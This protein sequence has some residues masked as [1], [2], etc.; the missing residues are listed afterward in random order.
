MYSACGK[1]HFQVEYEQILQAF[2]SSYP[3]LLTCRLDLGGNDRPTPIPVGVVGDEPYQAC[4][5]QYAE[6]RYFASGGRSTI[7][8]V[9]WVC[10]RYAADTAMPFIGLWL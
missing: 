6:Y 5:V 3:W 4:C 9:L 1:A 10:F 8:A 7:V 2:V